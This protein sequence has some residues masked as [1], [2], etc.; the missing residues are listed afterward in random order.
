MDGARVP[1]YLHLPVQILWFDM[2][3]IGVIL[4]SY[5]IWMVMDSWWLLPIVV[6]VPWMFKTMKADKPRGFLRHLLYAYG[7]QKLERY[8]GPQTMHFDE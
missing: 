8:P 5:A 2:E 4:A 7:L 6:L 3:D 1:R